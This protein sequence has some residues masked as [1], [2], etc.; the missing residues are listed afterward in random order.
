M[1]NSSPPDSTS[2]AVLHRERNGSLATL[3]ADRSKIKRSIEQARKDYLAADGDTAATERHRLAQCLTDWLADAFDVG[4][5]P[6][7]QQVLDTLEC[8]AGMACDADSAAAEAA[9][10]CKTRAQEYTTRVKI[11][12]ELQVDEAVRQLAEQDF[13]FDVFFDSNSEGG[14]KVVPTQNS[15]FDPDRHAAL[16]LEYL[17]CREAAE[18]ECTDRLFLALAKFLV[19]H[20]GVSNVPPAGTWLLQWCIRAARDEGRFDSPSVAKMLGEIAMQDSG[21]KVL[22]L[23]CIL[24]AAVDQRVPSAEARCLATAVYDCC[25]TGP[26][27]HVWLHGAPLLQSSQLGLLQRQALTM[28]LL[29]ALPRH[30][31]GTFEFASRR[32]DLLRWALTLS[33][34]GYTDAV[35][36]FSAKFL[37]PGGSVAVLVSGVGRIRDA[38]GFDRL[39]AS[40]PTSADRLS[41]QGLRPLVAGQL[42]G[43]AL[44]K[45][46][47]RWNFSETESIVPLLLSLIPQCPQSRR[48]MLVAVSHAFDKNGAA[49]REFLTRLRSPALRRSHVRCDEVIA[50]CFA[51][52]EGPECFVGFTDADKA[53]EIDSAILRADHILRFESDY[54]R[55]RASRFIAQAVDAYWRPLGDETATTLTEAAIVRWREFVMRLAAG[56]GADPH[57]AE[58]LTRARRDSGKWAWEMLMNGPR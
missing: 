7:A 26:E 8:L 55:R 12:R 25:M 49:L 29:R 38:E 54:E 11:D 20:Q 14:L 51:A 56:A 52:L 17:V 50:A 43:E 5:L 37:K 27:A 53:V 36:A 57:A 28:R 24:H 44:G 31:G 2:S 46:G 10:V 41:E 13:T 1:S 21:G 48:F 40:L 19:D 6:I 42:L 3:K 23:L 33:A 4:D 15:E 32:R 35:E 9:S 47:D 22:P 16:F 18:P 30:A 39:I 34:S 58:A 45:S